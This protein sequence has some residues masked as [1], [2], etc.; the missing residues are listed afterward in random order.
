MAGRLRQVELKLDFIPA[1]M[2]LTKEAKIF[3][4][5]AA[6]YPRSVACAPARPRRF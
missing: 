6:G 4:G 1:K 2:L 5:R 3:S